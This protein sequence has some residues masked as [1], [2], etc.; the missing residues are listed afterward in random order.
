MLRF[1][2]L[3]LYLFASYSTASQTVDAGGGYDPDGSPTANAGGGYD[4][5]GASLSPL[6]AADPLGVNPPPTPTAD[7]GAGNDPNG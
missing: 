3:L 1:V 2:L 4:P 5:N 6:A 7:A